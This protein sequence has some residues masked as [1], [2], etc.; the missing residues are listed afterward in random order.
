LKFASLLKRKRYS[1]IP[2]TCQSRYHTEIGTNSATSARL[3]AAVGGSQRP[4]GF[5]ILIP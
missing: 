4:F 5:Y 1:Y 3:P 2:I